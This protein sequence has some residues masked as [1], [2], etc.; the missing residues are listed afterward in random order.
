MFKREIQSLRV[1]RLE[2]RRVLSTSADIVLVVDLSNSS[3]DPGFNDILAWLSEGIDEID[4]AIESNGLTDRRYGVVG[5][6]GPDTDFGHSFVVGP[7]SLA[8]DQ[9]RLFSSS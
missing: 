3:D 9:D 6:G 7:G 8:N 2:D 5:F 4:S 1:E